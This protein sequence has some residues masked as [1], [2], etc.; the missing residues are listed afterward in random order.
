MPVNLYELKNGGASKCAHCGQPF[1]IT[2]S[3]VECWRSSIGALFCN[4]FCADD[5]EEALF[6]SRWSVRRSSTLGT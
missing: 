6:Q 5:A 4:E 3:G 1:R 2:D